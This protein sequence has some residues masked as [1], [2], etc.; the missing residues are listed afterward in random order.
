MDL[1]PLKYGE[2][3]LDD[4]SGLIPAI[5]TRRELDEHEARNILKV[6]VKYLTSPPSKRLARFDYAWFLKLHQQMF[7]DV[8]R[9]AGQ[10]RTTDLNVGSS[11]YQVPEDLAK[12]VGDLAYWQANWPDVLE[13]SVYLHVRA[14]KIHPF[15]NGNGRWSRMLQNVWLMRQGHGLCEWP[16]SLNQIESPARNEYIQ[17]IKRA[18][19]EHD[20]G[21]MTELCRRHVPG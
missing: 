11:A 18:V 14:V 12:L 20:Y 8:W 1:G 16:E 2:T 5:T 21:L 4:V 13:Q 6:V 19:N 17:C 3:P 15:L 10:L 7:G 9:W